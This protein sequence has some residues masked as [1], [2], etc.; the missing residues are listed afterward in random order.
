M[1]KFFKTSSS[2]DL[3][4]I[5]ELL[6]KRYT[7]IEYI[8]S[9]DFEEG[10]KIIELAKE[11]ELDNIL[12]D[13]WLVDYRNMRTNETFISFDDYKAKLTQRKTDISLDSKEDL[14]QMAQEIEKKLA[15][16][17]GE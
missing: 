13:R 8:L 9:L 16:K 11:K 2:I 14:L 15:E 7:N 3:I 17:R 6:L 5:Q 4:A 12:W 1:E 10:N